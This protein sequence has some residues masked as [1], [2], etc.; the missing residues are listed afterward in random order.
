MRIASGPGKAN[1]WSPACGWNQ[2]PFLST[3]YTVDELTLVHW[4]IYSAQ[5]P[6]LIIIEGR[7]ATH[8]LLVNS[9][10]QEV[11]CELVGRLPEYLGSGGFSDVWNFTAK[12]RSLQ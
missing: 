1:S 7:S 8:H 2:N 6:G 11:K 9:Y 10:T 12:T 3:S 4:L 5:T